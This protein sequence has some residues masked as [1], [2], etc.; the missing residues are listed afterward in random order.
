MCI[1]S[2]NK[3]NRM[4]KINKNKFLFFKLDEDLPHS[5]VFSL[6]MKNQRLHTSRLNYS[7]GPFICQEIL[8]W[9]SNFSLSQFGPHFLK[10]DSI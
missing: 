2:K 5:Y 6:K 4:H 1:F 10:N 7:F 3:N 9:S 8:V